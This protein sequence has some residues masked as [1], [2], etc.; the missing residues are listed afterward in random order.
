M[1]HA[2]T[3][4][5]LNCISVY[6]LDISLHVV[7]NRPSVFLS[8]FALWTDTTLF[9]LFLNFASLNAYSAILVDA[10][11]VVKRIAILA[12]SKSYSNPA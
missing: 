1:A 6:F 12:F 7:E 2:S 8:K 5:S 11:F 9:F 4:I 10:F 3:Y